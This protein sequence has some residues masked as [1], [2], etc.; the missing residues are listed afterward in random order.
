MI[1]GIV[2]ILLDSHYEN[3]NVQN[4]TIPVGYKL[5]WNDEFGT[6]MDKWVIIT[7]DWNNAPIDNGSVLLT[8]YYKAEQNYIS[9]SHVESKYSL[10]YGYIEFRARPSYVFGVSSD[11]WLMPADGSISPEIDILER[12]GKIDWCLNSIMYGNN[13]WGSNY[14]KTQQCSTSDGEYHI[15]SLLWEPD[16]IIWY[17]D[18]VQRWKAPPSF[19]HYFDVPMKIDMAM[20]SDIN[21]GCRYQGMGDA[22]DP[23]NLPTDFTV[24][25][26][27]VYQKS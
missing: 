17:V 13:I 19:I 15:F 23:K 7:E 16:K 8:A 2:L 14:P 21:V 3:K 24:D 12:P 11:L 6:N 18:G 1:S 9:R 20:C 27:R 25:Y 10:K 4:S 26:V 22:T 5:V